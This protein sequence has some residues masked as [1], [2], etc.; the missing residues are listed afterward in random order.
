MIELFPSLLFI[1]LIATLIALPLILISKSQK[2][3]NAQK[4]YPPIELLQPQPPKQSPVESQ[5][6]EQPQ[7]EPQTLTIPYP[8]KRKYLLTKNEWQ[9]YKSLKP[10]ADKYNLQILSKIRLADIIE[11]IQPVDNRTWGIYFNK[12]KSKHIDFALANPQNLYIEFLIE[13][14]DYTHNRQ[15]RIDRDKF[16]DDLCVHTGYILIHSHGDVNKI[17]NIIETTKKQYTYKTSKE[18]TE[19][20]S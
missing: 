6:K 14:D 8:Y 10:I 17:Q 19:V 5:T 18:L 13:L 15:K 3:K 2:N 9:F 16:V 12:I 1:A 4:H 7:A 11:V 20:N